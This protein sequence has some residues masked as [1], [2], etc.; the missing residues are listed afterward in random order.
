MADPVGLH[1]EPPPPPEVLVDQLSDLPEH[2]LLKILS[3]LP[4]HRAV[5]TSC[6]SRCFHGLWSALPSLYFHRRPFTI[7]PRFVKM[8][9]RALVFGRDRSVPLETLCIE[10]CYYSRC[11]LPQKSV[12]RWINR[13]AHLGVEHLR[14]R[15]ESTTATAVCCSI[16][17]IRSLESLHIETSDDLLRNHKALIPLDIVSTSLKSLCL[18][19]NIDSPELTRLIGELPVLEYLE[20]RGIDQDIIDISS[21]SIRTL[22]LGCKSGKIMKLAFP[23]LDHIQ[24]CVANNLEMFHGEMPL[25]SKAGFISRSP[26]E[27][28]VLVL[29]SILKSVANAVVLELSIETYLRCC[30]M[31]LSFPR[32]EYFNF[33][34]RMCLLKLFQAEMPVLR[35]ADIH[36]SSAKEEFALQ[37]SNFLKCVANSVYLKLAIRDDWAQLKPF[38][39]FN[40]NKKPPL[41]PRLLSLELSTSCHEATIKDVIALLENCPILNYLETSHV[42]PDMSISKEKKKTNWQSKLPRNSEGNYKHACFMDLHTGDEKSR[43]IKLLSRRLTS[44][45]RKIGEL[46]I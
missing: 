26:R 42:D 37:I 15:L 24:I 14:L 4:V 32:L 7:T 45:K 18:W 34:C 19:L 41:F 27:V 17:S 8:V 35:K 29:E 10:T 16:F 3:L 31:Q 20:L 12:A 6:L 40:S 28:P 30:E 25:V 1:P 22:K 44:K 38:H 46:A 23:K 13:A 36:L 9:D 43:V 33:S 2:L 39:L 11:S 21:L 5:Q